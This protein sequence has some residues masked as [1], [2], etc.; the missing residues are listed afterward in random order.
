M[1]LYLQVITSVSVLLYLMA[2]NAKHLMNILRE[3]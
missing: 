3:G 1:S 2:F